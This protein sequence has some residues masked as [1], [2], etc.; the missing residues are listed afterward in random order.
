MLA[1]GQSIEKLEDY[2]GGLPKKARDK[3]VSNIERARLAGDNDPTFEMILAC[4]RRLDRSP[5]KD[6]DPHSERSHLAER[7]FFSPIEEFL[8]SDTPDTQCPGRISRSSLVPIWIWLVRDVA[9]GMFDEAGLSRKDNVSAM[10]EKE[11]QNRCERIRKG[12][13]EEALHQAEDARAIKHERQRLAGQ[14][15]GEQVFNDLIATL[16]ALAMQDKID[17]FRKLLNDFGDLGD[18]S[19]MDLCRQ[20][21]SKFVTDP[22]MGYHYGAMISNRLKDPTPLIRYIVHAVGSDEPRHIS[23]SPYG[24]VIELLLSDAER[25]SFRINQQCRSLSD[26]ELID[27]EL[28]IYQT[29]IDAMSLQMDVN[30]KSDWCEKIKEL[31]KKTSAF[32]TVPLESIQRLMRSCLDP[33]AKPA[34]SSREFIELKCSLHILQRLRRYNQSFASNQSV[35]AAERDLEKIFSGNSTRLLSKEILYKVGRIDYETLTDRLLEIS[36]MVYGIDYT[37]NLRRQRDAFLASATPKG[38]FG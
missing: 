16:D 22:Q 23:A 3:L 11:L 38:M 25:A 30:G 33:V 12:V 5:D 21:H 8:I 28:S 13:I 17:N 31:R 10:D 6:Y 35:A 4:T 2:L 37:V 9:Y 24:R 14:I 7:A 15:G 36:E 29:I 20:I 27:K 19:N 1:K 18:L 26:P 34:N 32:L